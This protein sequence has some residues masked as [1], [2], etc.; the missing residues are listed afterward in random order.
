MF[1]ARVRRDYAR[2]AGAEPV[3]LFVGRALTG[4]A[5]AVYARPT[6]TCADIT[7]PEKRA[8][9]FG[10]I[11]AAFGLGFILVRRSV[12]FIVRDQSARAVLRRGRPGDSQLLVR[13]FRAAREPAAERRRRSRWHAPTRSARCARSRHAATCSRSRCAR[14]SAAAF[15]R[16]PIDLGLT[17]LRVRFSPRRFGGTLALSAGP[18]RS[19]RARLTG[20][21]VARIGEIRAAPLGVAVGMSG[22]LGYAFITQAWMTPCSRSAACKVW[23][24]RSMNAML[25]RL[26]GPE[27]EGELQAEWRATADLISPLALTNVRAFLGQTP[28]SALPGRGVSTGCD[29]CVDRAVPAAC[30]AGEAHAIATAIAKLRVHDRAVVPIW[31]LRDRAVVHNGRLCARQEGRALPD[32]DILAGQHAHAG[33]LPASTAIAVEGSLC[34]PARPAAELALRAPPLRLAHSL[35]FCRRSVAQPLRS[36]KRVGSRQEHRRRRA[37]RTL[38]MVAGRLAASIARDPRAHGKVAYAMSTR[39]VSKL[40]AERSGCASPSTS[41]PKVKCGRRE[42]PQ[43]EFRSGA[44]GKHTN[45]LC[46]TGP[47]TSARPRMCMLAPRGCLSR[48]G[49]SLR[50]RLTVRCA[51]PLG[52]ATANRHDGAVAHRV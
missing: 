5:G 51:P 26:L 40:L 13:P 8:Q 33:P 35:R 18:W 31:R 14:S 48:G 15:R 38:S 52:R 39:S 4:I 23:R 16:V 3:W 34:L 12:S 10:M 42:G 17:R 28:G 50:L 27:R 7:P 41:E 11:G 6:P 36:S 32:S 25:S 47:L 49:P 37:P 21:L 20:R 24:C 1:D 2:W 19:C 44:C 22:V 43:R 30:A 46:G 29:V 45:E 9:S